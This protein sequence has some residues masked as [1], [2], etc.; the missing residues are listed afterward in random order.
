MRWGSYLVGSKWNT[1]KAGTAKSTQVHV[2]C[3][4]CTREIFL[5]INTNKNTFFKTFLILY[6][7][8]Q[9]LA[10]TPTEVLESTGRGRAVVTLVVSQT[11]PLVHVRSEN[12]WRRPVHT[13]K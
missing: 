4:E 13:Y 6:T 1:Q 12:H 3:S 10:D 11:K 5:Y 7:R 2:I 8:S 9:I